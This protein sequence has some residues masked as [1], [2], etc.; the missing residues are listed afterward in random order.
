MQLKNV[1]NIIKH[2]GN[3]EIIL[4]DKPM[5]ANAENNKSVF[6]KTDYSYGDWRGYDKYLDYEVV[7][8]KSINNYLT[9]YIADNSRKYI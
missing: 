3:V 1:A 5:F 2:G 7:G 8:F 4:Q 9:I 6:I